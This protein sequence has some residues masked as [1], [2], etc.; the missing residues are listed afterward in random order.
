MVTCEGLRGLLEQSLDVLG[1]LT[2][3]WQF[4]H[5]PNYF[6]L[7]IIVFSIIACDEEQEVARR[8][9]AELK[10]RGQYRTTLLS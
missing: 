3:T 4:L 10:K 7:V 1:G 6:L 2:L 9:G 5:R 8:G